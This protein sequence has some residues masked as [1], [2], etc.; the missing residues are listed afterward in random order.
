MRARATTARWLRE[1]GTRRRRLAVTFAVFVAALCVRETRA[2]TWPLVKDIG[3]NVV[4]VENADG[5]AMTV[6][7]SGGVTIS[8]DAVVFEGDAYA[9]YK[10]TF[11]TPST[12]LYDIETRLQALFE[13]L[14]ASID[15]MDGNLTTC[16]NGK[17]SLLAEV[18]ALEAAWD[19]AGARFTPP[20]CTGANARNLIYV[21]DATLGHNVWSCVCKNDY[22]GTNCEI[23]PCD[24]SAFA[25][26]G[27]CAVADTLAVGAQCDLSCGS[28]LVQNTPLKCTLQGGVGVLNAP[29]CVACD[30]CTGCD[31]PG[32]TNYDYTDHTGANC[33]AIPCN[34]TGVTTAGYTLRAGGT[35][36]L[37]ANGKF[38]S[39]TTCD[40]ECA[41]DSIQD[42][43]LV[44]SYDSS[45][46]TNSFNA[47]TCVPCTGDYTGANCAIAPC[48]TSAFTTSGTCAISATLAVGGSCK[49]SC[50]EDGEVRDAPL[51]CTLQGGVGVLIE[52]TCTACDSCTSCDG[53]GRTDFDY[54]DYTGADC[55]IP[56]CDL[57]VATSAQYTLRV[58]GTCA[59]DANRK[60]PV[61]A[62][63]DIE[64]A[65]DSIQNSQLTCSW[66]GTSSSFN[67]PS[68]VACTG[69]YTGANCAIAPCNVATYTTGACASLSTLPVGGSC[70]VSCASGSVQDTPLICSLPSSSAVSGALNSPT[71]TACDSCT[72]C[73]GPG[74]LIDNDY[75]DHTGT[76]C[77]IPPCNVTAEKSIGHPV[78]EGGTCD[79]DANGMIPVG[80]KCDIE[81]DADSIQD[82]QVTCSW[83][84]TSSSFDFSSFSCVPCTGNYTGAN[85]VT[86]PC[87]VGSGASDGSCGAALAV[88][89][90]CAQYCVE[91]GKFI[92]SASTCSASGSTI[93]S[94][95]PCRQMDFTLNGYASSFDLETST[96]SSKVDNVY[97]FNIKTAEYV[98]S[99]F[100]NNGDEKYYYSAIDLTVSESGIYHV[101]WQHAVSP[102]GDYVMLIYK[103][104]F[105][106]GKPARN[107]AF[108]NDD[109]YINVNS[110]TDPEATDGTW[111]DGNNY[112]KNSNNALVNAPAAFVS[113]DEDASYVV[114]F[115][116]Y[117]S[118]S[119]YP[120]VSF[121]VPAQVSMTCGMLDFDG[122]DT[123]YAYHDDEELVDEPALTRGYCSVRAWA[124][125]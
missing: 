1:P 21:Y 27:S 29:T 5:G 6:K 60:I 91:S 44:C 105:D 34:V 7:A 62:T 40:I 103:N 4:E 30:S 74:S 70:D 79:L 43:Q 58:G 46:E 51:R 52:P 36:D 115:T 25:T 117:Y 116:S 37:D 12:R 112:Y 65:A 76:D 101:S 109:A 99:S 87:V 93:S 94:P 113:L 48:D 81:C 85:C 14:T 3:T 98:G 17:Q 108:G 84:G 59:A 72:N 80:E 23:P 71:C 47:P 31:G 35:C 100:T 33:A 95:G 102:T 97:Q 68:C 90:S 53:H 82:S 111:Y 78:R 69:D 118:H 2:A 104:S 56:P 55:S 61:G 32:R 110:N 124:P 19:S 83:D 38:V 114:V 28:N 77:S 88:G 73:D 49:L 66:D 125:P 54:T 63:C 9:E 26:L 89:A 18:E 41:A 20:T 122:P 106:P 22:T 121:E 119:T 96:I 15:I 13:E 67:A 45:T 57:T 8:A 24:T 120:S 16:T 10:D 11:D 64:C 42:S 39:G 107:L 75:T 86:A 50:S 123:A 92:T